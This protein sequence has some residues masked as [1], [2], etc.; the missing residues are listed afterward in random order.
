MN[1]GIPDKAAK[2]MEKIAPTGLI[3]CPKCGGLGSCVTITR[4]GDF[5]SHTCGCGYKRGKAKISD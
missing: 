4:D 5:V 3:T 1:E 2:L